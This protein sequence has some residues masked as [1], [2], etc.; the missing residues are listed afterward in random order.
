M[1]VYVDKNEK[2]VVSLQT[3]NFW[4]KILVSEASFFSQYR[5]YDNFNAVGVRIH[6]HCIPENLVKTC[7][8]A[9]SRYLAALENKKVENE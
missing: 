5:V 1:G 8:G 3:K 2:W 9:Y 4:L 7:K 6:E